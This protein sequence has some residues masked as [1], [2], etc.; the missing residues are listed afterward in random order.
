[1]C[2]LFVAFHGLA[3]SGRWKNHFALIAQFDNFTVTAGNIY[4]TGG[5]IS[6]ADGGVVSDVLT[7]NSDLALVNG[8]MS[9][10]TEL[11]DD[12]SSTDRLVIVENMTGNGVLSVTNVGGLGAAAT[13]GILVVEVQGSASGATLS[14]AAP[15]IVGEWQYHLVKN[16][17][18]WYLKSSHR[19]TPRDNTSKPVPVN[20][21]WAMA[22]LG[23]MISGFVYRTLR[24]RQT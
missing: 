6:L 16:G 13:N 18:N 24:R 15:L 23:L 8:R 11:G 7:I 4:N 10:D 12:T 17:N 20:A 9:I 5:N 19:G 1:V 14:L 21:P 3:A 22:I 2:F